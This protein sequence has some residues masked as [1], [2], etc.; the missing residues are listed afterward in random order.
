MSNA[1]Q[2]WQYAEEAMRR[3]DQS[4]NEKEKLALIELARTWTHAAMVSKGNDQS[5]DGVAVDIP[6]EQWAPCSRGAD[7]ARR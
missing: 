5:K 6:P 4:Q 2:F 3:A 1:E 7:Q